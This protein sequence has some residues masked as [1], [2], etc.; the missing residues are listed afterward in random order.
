MP[1]V[2]RRDCET[3][4]LLVAGREIHFP[5]DAAPLLQYLLDRAPVAV[6]DFCIE[7]EGGFDRDE[8]SSFLHA[9]SSEGVIALLDPALL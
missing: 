5:E 8:L 2:F 7:F 4:Q 1:R 6:T 9:L 3:I